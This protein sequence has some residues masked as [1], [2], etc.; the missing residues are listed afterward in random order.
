MVLGV[1]IGSSGCKEENW[2]LRITAVENCLRP[3]RLR[4]LSFRG[5]VCLALSSCWYVVSLLPMPDCVLGELNRLISFLLG[6]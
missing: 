2:R 3:W 6:W 1:F 4:K 5:C